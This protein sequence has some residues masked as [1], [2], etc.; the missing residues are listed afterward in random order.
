MLENFNKASDVK[1]TK[2]FISISASSRGGLWF[3]EY[4]FTPIILE[5]DCGNEALGQAVF[6]ALKHSRKM[7][8]EEWDELFR[9][10]FLKSKS[11]EY[12]NYLMERF[13]YKNK[14]QLYKTMKTVHVESTENHL[15]IL[16]THQDRLG[17][18]CG[19]EGIEPI[20]TPTDIDAELLGMKMREA[21][22]LCTSI[23]K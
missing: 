17:G 18:F 14:R 9:S 1:F 2:D 3:F 20:T 6:E 4:R 11:I 10:G 23:Y 22:K 19:I 12:S 7:P 16:P 21:Y 5:V 15:E 8:L 13:N